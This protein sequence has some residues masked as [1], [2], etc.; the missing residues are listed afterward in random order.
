LNSA[1]LRA[2]RRGAAAVLLLL[3]AACGKGQE[4]TLTFY[5]G[6]HAVSVRYPASWS[7]QERSD[8]NIWSRYF[9][10]PGKASVSATLL[11]AAHAGSL[12]EYAR[13]YLAGQGAPSVQDAARQGVPGRIWRYASADGQQRF[14]LLLL[15]Q[16]GR[17]YG[18]YE[19]APAPDFERHQKAL[20]AIAE[21]LTLERPEGW[22]ER[23][24]EGQPLTVRL[25]ASWTPGQSFGSGGT[26]FMQ[27][28]SPALG[29]EKGQTIHA[30]LTATAEAAP[31]G[32][33]EGYAQ[34]M[35][36]RM[37]EGYKVLSHVEWRGG[38][39]DMMRAETPISVARVKRYLWTRGGRGYALSCDAREDVF[40]RV[41]R[42]CDAIAGT[43]QLDGQPLPAAQ[44]PP[45]A[46]PSP[47]PSARAIMSH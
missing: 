15:Q 6:E 47:S 25:P 37:G 9:A 26:Y 12:D 13:S 17:V 42:W 18:I 32:T 8:E 5:S 20:Q 43:L 40:P 44:A 31:S 22:V 24:L 36:T 30:S 14:V 33:L 28:L 38:Y 10:L 7:S 46:G 2:T 16:G 21:S 35:R 23:R 34:T 4:P 29:I 39:V 3:L 41:T 1:A 27:F 45:L 19:Q 11:V